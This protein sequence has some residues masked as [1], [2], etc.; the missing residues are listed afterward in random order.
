MY[1][2][3]LTTEIGMEACGWE[4]LMTSA[5]HPKCLGDATSFN[6]FSKRLREQLKAISLVGPKALQTKYIMFPVF[7]WMDQPHAKQSGVNATQEV[8]R[9]NWESGNECQRETECFGNNT[10]SVAAMWEKLYTKIFKEGY[11][12]QIH[13]EQ[14]LFFHFSI[15]S[16]PLCASK[17]S[18]FLL[19]NNPNDYKQVQLLLRVGGRAPFNDHF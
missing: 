4:C 18:D 6:W 10:V 9:P 16:S 17:P 8:T 19:L 11:F 1:L 3:R 12:Y 7:K 14:A 13:R 2:I 5:F 15:F